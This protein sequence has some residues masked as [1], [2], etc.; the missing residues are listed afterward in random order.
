MHN[1]R[2]RMRQNKQLGLVSIIKC[3]PACLYGYG[4]HVST[5]VCTYDIYLSVC[6]IPMFF[7]FILW[8]FQVP[9]VNERNIWNKLRFACVYYN[10]FHRPVSLILHLLLLS[11]SP[12]ASL[13]V[14]VFLKM[15]NCPLTC[16]NPSPSQLAHRKRDYYLLQAI[17]RMNQNLPDAQKILLALEDW[18]WKHDPVCLLRRNQCLAILLHPWRDLEVTE[19]TGG[20]NFLG[21]KG[22]DVASQGNNSQKS[23]PCGFI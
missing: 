22:M 17:V 7:A 6:R 23:V 21:G 1:L 16:P 19:E 8:Y 5:H 15:L 10:A 14:S 3:M 13:P 18:K 20:F 4:Y 11:L 12:S 9:K 2:E